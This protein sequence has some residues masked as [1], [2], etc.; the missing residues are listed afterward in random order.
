[1]SAE[2]EQKRDTG[3]GGGQI[4]L[5]VR[6]FLIG[7]HFGLIRI[8]HTYITG[9]SDFIWR[10]AKL[11]HKSFMSSTTEPQADTKPYTHYD[12]LQLAP[13]DFGSL[14]RDD[15]KAAY[16]RALL[17]HH[18]DKAPSS[19]IRSTLKP[20]TNAPTTR[21]SIDQIVNAYE[22]LS[23][24]TKRFGYGRILEQSDSYGRQHRNGHEETHI[25][26]ESYDLEDLT[27]NEVKDTWSKGCRCGDE[28][29]YGV[30]ESDLDRESQHGEIYVGCRGCSLFIK[31]QFAVEET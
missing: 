10:C 14:S 12:V 4:Y 2:V 19:G 13:H 1:M 15:I 20:P 21:Y 29:G 3:V 9:G 28:R 18:P 11:I 24:P 23:D 8:E 6:C 7:W 16:R 22:I 17:I 31:V 27:Y 30:S 5:E 26:V 25:G